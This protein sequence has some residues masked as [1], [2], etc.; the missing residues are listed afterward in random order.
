MTFPDRATVLFKLADRPDFSSHSLEL[1]AVVFS[2]THQRVA[3]RC[4][5]STVIYDYRE[6]KKTALPPFM[7]EKFR[8]TYDRQAE[9]KRRYRGHAQEVIHAVQDLESSRRA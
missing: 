6:A 3:A 5:E 4:I 2:E 7:V 8:E 1:E 9:A